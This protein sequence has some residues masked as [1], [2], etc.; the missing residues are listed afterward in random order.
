MVETRQQKRDRVKKNM[1]IVKVVKNKKQEEEE[2]RL[3]T[4]ITSSNGW[5]L[6]FDNDSYYVM[7]NNYYNEEGDNYHQFKEEDYGIKMAYRKAIKC[8]Y[9]KVGSC[10]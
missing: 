8:F 5:N 4:L 1:K 6:V 3:C 10:V 7:T 2:E 9:D